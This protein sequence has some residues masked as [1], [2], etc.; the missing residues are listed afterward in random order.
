MRGLIVKLITRLY[1]VETSEG[2]YKCKTRGKLR[3]DGLEPLVGDE[4][5]ISPQAGDEAIIDR[6]HPR[7]N[8]LKRPRIANCKTLIIMLAAEPGPDFE[9]VDRL[10]LQAELNGARP[11]LCLNKMD[12]AKAEALKEEIEQ[13]YLPA[14]TLVVTSSEEG[15]GIEALRDQLGE[16]INV[17]CG[18]SGVGKSSII[19]VL[20]PDKGMEV[21]SLSQKLKRGRHTTRHSELID[22]GLKRYICDSP[23]FSSFENL[24]IEST[25]LLEYM[26]DLYEYRGSCRFL[27]CK[28]LKEP[29]CALR[30]AV[31]EGRISEARYASYVKFLTELE[32]REK[33]YGS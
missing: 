29:D 19:N 25:K 21:G 3:L 12:M 30:L 20:I 26:P 17:L 2:I 13:R 18:Q 16:G 6:V 1:Y 10:I 7:Y 24:N 4:V 8:V 33:N 15:L 5:D 23:G 22:L 11:I 14:Y 28:H 27:N 32:A 31:E 9:F